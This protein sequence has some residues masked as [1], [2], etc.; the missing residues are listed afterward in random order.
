MQRANLPPTRGDR[1]ASAASATA[2]KRKIPQRHPLA[3][4]GVFEP[5]DFGLTMSGEGST[6]AALCIDHWLER[7]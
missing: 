7:T 3:T 5:A 1:Q 4:L 2:A 6:A